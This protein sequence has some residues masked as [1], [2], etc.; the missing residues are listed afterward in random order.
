MVTRTPRDPWIDRL[1]EYLDGELTGGDALSLEAHLEECAECRLALADLRRVVARARE[2]PETP[3]AEDLW[4]AIRERIEADA[5]VAPDTIA[6]EAV[7]ASERPARRR[8]LD[9]RTRPRWWARPLTLSWA[10]AAA[11]A[12]LLVVLAGGGAYLVLRPVGGVAP[13]AGRSPA[14]RSAVEPGATSA[15]LASLPGAPERERDGT[16]A[17]G[18]QAIAE[19]G[20]PGR[21]SVRPTDEAVAVSLDPQYDGAIA[22]LQNILIRE[23]AN[24][25][26]ST[27]RI[28]EQ[29]LALIDRALA[30]ARR[31]VASDPGNP[32]LRAH[33]AST[34]RRKVELL[35]RA[36]EIASPRG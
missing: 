15:P 2:L 27:V 5:A 3:P 22:Q 33:L 23:R 20:R 30:E 8:V 29:N 25:D 19:H 9:V 31:A 14:E 18:D 34:M 12:V 17:P 32:Y 21:G 7:A 28:L 16:G 10:Q 11:A 6:P 1:S 36:T 24:L 4:P 26:T 13:V 35:R